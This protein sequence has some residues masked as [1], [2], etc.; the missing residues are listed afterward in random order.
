VR[1][2]A[3]AGRALVALLRCSDLLGPRLGFRDFA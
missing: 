3:D 2:A 1:L